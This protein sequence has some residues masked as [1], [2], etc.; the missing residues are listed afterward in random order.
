MNPDDFHYT[1]KRCRF[2]ATCAIDPCGGVTT[3]P[4][5]WEKPL[6]VPLAR[7]W[8][9]AFAEG[10]KRIEFRP[11]GIVVGRDG[12]ERSSPW[13]A[14]TCR[15]GRPALLSNGYHVAGR[16]PAVIESYSEHPDAGETTEAFDQIYPEHRARGG[17]V[18]WITFRV[19][20]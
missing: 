16:I 11:A 19:Q 7:Q 1:D 14:R 6:F 12:V 9:R 20:P 18:G 5:G 10:R 4:D 13:N 15:L 17:M 8:Y 3:C 2:H